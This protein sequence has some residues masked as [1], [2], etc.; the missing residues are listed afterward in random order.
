MKKKTIAIVV[1]ILV[2]LVL[3]VPIPFR[4]KDGGSVEYKALLY[5]IT[6]VHRLNPDMQ[7][8]Q[9]YLE[10]IIIEIFGMEVY[11]SVR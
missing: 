8:E 10:G 11:N 4:L 9:A 2:I 6:D 5:T 3:F 7:S 1:I